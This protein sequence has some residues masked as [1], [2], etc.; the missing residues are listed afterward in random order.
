M[1]RLPIASLI[2]LAALAA[3]LFTY[4]K[5]GC[6]KIGKDLE[7]FAPTVI[8]GKPDGTLG[9]S[10]LT[11]I[12]TVFKV[13]YY[14]MISQV[15][16]TSNGATEAERTDWD[17]AVVLIK[18]DKAEGT[19]FLVHMPDGPAVI[20]NLHVLSGNPHFHVMTSD[21]REIPILSLKGASDR[22]LALLGIQD[23]HYHYLD[24]ATDDT[25]DTQ[26]GDEVI[27][28]GNSEGGEVTLDTAGKVLGLGP[29][30][31]EISNPIYHGNSGGPVVEKA[32]GKVLGVV[33][34]AMTRP[35]TDVM[36]QASRANPGS[37]ITSD[38]RYFGLRLD[39]VSQWEPYAM[40]EFAVQ[41]NFLEN[42]HENSVCLDSILNGVRY[43]KA[44]LTSKGAP[45]SKYFMHNQ[46]LAAEINP[47]LIDDP[48][49]AAFIED[50]RVAILDILQFGQRDLDS[51]QNARNFYSFEWQRAKEEAAYRKALMK[52][53]QAVNDKIN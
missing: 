46:E 31:I 36:D 28:P 23:D 40:E 26:T 12:G 13:S 15:Q 39:T 35:P 6:D 7:A 53:A 51:I 33:T 44:G 38:V 18:G 5:T 1:R 21:G 25:T 37:A 22:D 19:G 4:D 47:H 32:T 3:W 24:L 48:E 50:V 43:E 16:S 34:F 41:T 20:T 2:L 11:D 42:F 10:V 17:T 8:H 49:H 14:R 29:D 30:R 45:D 52:E 9:Q 27:T